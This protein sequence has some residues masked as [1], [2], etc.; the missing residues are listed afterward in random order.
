MHSTPAP[1]PRVPSTD[2]VALVERAT[3]PR[4]LSTSIALIVIIA[5]SLVAGLAVYILRMRAGTPERDVPPAA[6]AT[7]SRP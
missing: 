1:K 4:Q 3:A 2:T 5:L 6:H 7:A